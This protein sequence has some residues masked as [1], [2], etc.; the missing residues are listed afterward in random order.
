MIDLGG[1]PVDYPVRLTKIIVTMRP[2]ILYVNEEIPVRNR[3]IWI[4][5]L[6]IVGPPERM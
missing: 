5:R 4:D 6:G 1:E 3:V 2:H